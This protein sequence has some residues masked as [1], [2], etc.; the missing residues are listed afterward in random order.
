MRKI[1]ENE[2]KEILEKHQKYLEEKGGECANLS[3]TD[4]S[5]L[6]LSYTNLS[7][8]KFSYANFKYVNF[9]YA[10]LCGANFAKANLSNADFSNANLSNADFVEANLNCVCLKYAN[11]DCADLTYASLRSANLECASFVDT[12]LYFANLTNAKFFNP[13]FLYTNVRGAN[14]ADAVVRDMKLDIVEYSHTTA[15]LNLACPEEGSFIGFKKVIYGAHEC[16]AKLLITDDSKRSSAT[17]RKCRASKVKVLGFYDYDKNE[18]PFTEARSISY[19][20]FIYHKG[21]TIE[22]KDFDDNRWEECST[23]IHFFITFDEAKNY[24]F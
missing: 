14:F 22:V 17:T 4:L 2:L 5:C 9:E 23:G 3:Y 11:L 12:S 1:T 18:L 20:N 13:H 6:D 7:Y 19:I 8:A 16:I 15:F 10:N 24:H 21:E